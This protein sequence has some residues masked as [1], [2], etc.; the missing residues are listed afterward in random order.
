M[1]ELTFCLLLGHHDKKLGGMAFA[2]HD[3]TKSDSRK[4]VIVHVATY[5]TVELK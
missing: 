1:G 5:K 2:Y 4:F 3:R